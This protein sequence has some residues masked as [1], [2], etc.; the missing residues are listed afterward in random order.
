[1]GKWVLRMNKQSATGK[2]SRSNQRALRPIG[3]LIILATAYAVYHLNFKQSVGHD[4]FELMGTVV[5]IKVVV[6]NY[7]DAEELIAETRSEMEKVVDVMNAYNPESF[8]A[9]LNDLPT[10][11]PLKVEADEAIILDVLEKSREV[12]ELSDGAFDITFASVGRY[13][14]FDPSDPRLPSDEEIERAK[15]RIDYRQVVIDK[16]EGTV[17]LSG[18]E[19]RIDLGG[20]AKGTVV[21]VAI[22]FLKRHGA[23]GALVNAGGD[24]YGFGTKADGQSWTVGLQHP[25]KPT[26]TVIPGVYIRVGGREVGDF[27]V[28]TSGDYERSFVHEGTRYHHIIDP[29]TGLPSSGVSSVTVI[30]RSA[31][32]AD[33]MATAIFVMGAE[34]GMALAE[35]RPELEAVMITDDL[36]VLATSGL[37]DSVKGIELKIGASN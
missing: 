25:R 8:V 24:M 34:E 36:E 10:S 26:G 1:M 31:E 16:E 28:V 18:E 27:A 3:L 30:S 11:T 4:L 35:N 37:A 32:W 13:W 23:E 33:A 7:V 2:S 20:I 12:S 5:D 21:D 9:R 14:R 29:R 19:T 6:P 15:N 17:M 22:R